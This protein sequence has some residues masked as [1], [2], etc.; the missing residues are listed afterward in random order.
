M[1]S[2]LSIDSSNWRRIVNKY[3]NTCVVCNRTM[4]TGDEIL[5]NPEMPGQSR[6]L[7]EVCEWLGTRKKMPKRRVSK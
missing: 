2:G 4:V 5:W 7:P 1:K 3:K 6:H